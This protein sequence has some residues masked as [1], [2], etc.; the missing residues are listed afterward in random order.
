M[1]IDIDLD[2]NNYE[3]ADILNLFKIPVLFNDK[4]LREAKVIVLQMHPD[5]SRLPKEYFLF[6]TKAYKMLYEIYKVRFPDEKKYKETGFSYSAVID[7]EL[8]QN[9]SKTAH[10]KED[11]EYYKTEE[12]AYKKLQKMDSENF[13]KW[14][15]EKFEKFR[16]HDDEQDGGYE[17][18]FRNTKN[19]DGLDAGEAGEDDDTYDKSELGDTWGE[20]NERIER[21]KKMLRDKMALIETNE[22]MSYDS[23]GCGGN[24][25]YYGLGREAPR[26]YSSG[27]FSSL[28]YEDLKKAHTESVIPVTTEDFVNRKKYTSVNEM[29]MFRDVEKTQYDFSRENHTTKLDQATA[30][31]V[32]QDMQR[33]FR[34]AKQDEIARDIN[35]KFKSEFFQITN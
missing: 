32:E 11:R 4:H 23:V 22:V 7:R 10:N 17:D 26:E 19:N 24:G 29:Q 5:K 1:D 30:T 2:I 16:M 25:G 15:N 35:A 3:L 6:F 33:V 18:W 8:N 31:Q 12:E 34:M 13:N 14:F 28:Q 27:L 21:K 20:R 9:K